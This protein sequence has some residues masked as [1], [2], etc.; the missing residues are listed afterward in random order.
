MYSEAGENLGLAAVPKGKM[1]L[2]V[3]QQ[4]LNLEP[5][6]VRSSRDEKNLQIVAWEKRD[7][8][9]YLEVP[10]NPA[11]KNTKEGLKPGLSMLRLPAPLSENEEPVYHSHDLAIDFESLGDSTAKGRISG[12]VED[13]VLGRTHELR[14]R[15]ACGLERSP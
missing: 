8:R 6:V 14:A 3:G 7:M 5:C 1:E 12:R 11:L 15:F 4:T 13:L 2:G 9:L 10:G